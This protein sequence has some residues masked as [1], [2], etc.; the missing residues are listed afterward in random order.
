MKLPNR[1][2]LPGLITV[3]LFFG[4]LNQL[5]AQPEYHYMPAKIG[6]HN[7]VYDD[8]KKDPKLVPW[9]TWDNALEREMNWYLNAPVNDHGYPSYVHIT[10]MDENYQAYRND[11]I[12]A[13]QNGMGIISS[14]PSPL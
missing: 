12:P 14:L 7:A 9:T 8:N 5:S 10:F 3:F 11:F 1:K 6:W 13:T 4:G 2:F